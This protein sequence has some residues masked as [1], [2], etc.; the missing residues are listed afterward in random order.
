MIKKIAFILLL[1][2]AIACGTW[3]YLYLTNLKRPTT[4]PLSVLPDNCYMLLETKSLHQL[5]EK[6]NQ[7]N[8]MWEELLKT[9]AVKQFNKMLQKADSLISNSTNS[10]QFGVQ[11]VFVALYQNK[12]TDLLAAFN[13]TDINTNDLFISFLEKN[14]SAKK[15]SANFYEC[16]QPNYTFYVS[17][18]AGLVVLSGD[19]NF[20]QSAVKSNKNPLSKNKIFTEA[21]QSEDNESDV[22]VFV[23]LPN[24]YQNG[25]DNFLANPKQNG[26]TDNRYNEAWLSADVAVNSNEINAQGFFSNDST[27]FYNTL[28]NQQAISFKDAFGNLPYNISGLQALSIK[29]Y[30]TFIYNSY[31]GNKEWRKKILQSYTEKLNADAQIEIEKFIGDY[32]ILFEQEGSRFG[33]VNFEQEKLAVDFLVAVTD[34]SFRSVDSAWIYSDNEK[35]LFSLLNGN[36][37]TQE[38]KY[39]CEANNTFLFGNDIQALEECK[40]IIEQKNNV[41]TNERVINF[42]N[43]NLSVESAYLFY[44]DVFKCREKITNGLSKNIIKLLYQSPEMLDKY[45]SVALT[46]EKLKNNLFFKACANFNPKTKLYQNTLWE[47]LLDT[48]LYNNPTP[49]KNHITNETE[50]VCTDVSNNLYLVSNTGKILWKKNIG[51]KILSEIKQVDYFSNNKLQLLF[52]TENHL[53]I[54]DRNGNNISGFPVKLSMPAVGGLTLFDYENNQNYRLWIPLKNNTTVCYAINGK[55]LVDFTPIKNTGN[56]TRLVLQQKDYFILID[57]LGNINVTNRKGETRIKINSKITDRNA[58][59]FIE[60]GKNLE[61]TNIYYVNKSTKKLCKISLTDKVQEIAIPEENNIELVFID[62]LQ[63]AV[64]PLLICSTERSIDMF[65]FFGKKLYERVLDKKTQLDLK[66]LMYREKHFYAALEANTNNL[67]LIDMIENK[68]TDTEIKLTKLPDNCTLINNEKPYLIGFY[69]N[70]VFCI[71]Q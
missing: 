15:T 23:H 55:Q 64:S 6:L 31:V 65:D 56:V 12:K 67:L 25:W 2:A 29:N 68:V 54:I 62:T 61:S 45:E 17:V 38:F 11:S 22:N 52:N 33:M 60:E 58:S 49:V 28:I 36:F 71:K 4:N 26:S 37:F 46:V 14:F 42:M 24:F 63:N 20:L 51:E 53:Y 1:V 19:V 43:K 69:G 32:A 8:L 59:V 50:L 27:A 7:G 16:K 21:Y 57:T 44:A 3:G 40:K 66:S 13:L 5:S 35:H 18:N 47:T 39:V 10:N 48:S 41:Q 70:K 9:D 30:N 34:S